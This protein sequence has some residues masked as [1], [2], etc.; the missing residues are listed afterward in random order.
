MALA[1]AVALLVAE[2]TAPSEQQKK[3]VSMDAGNTAGSSQA[4]RCGEST[5]DRSWPPV[6]TTYTTCPIQ[7]SECV[8]CVC[9]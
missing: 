7:G 4:S 5:P 2:R 9:L 6:I 8:V 3:L 1:V